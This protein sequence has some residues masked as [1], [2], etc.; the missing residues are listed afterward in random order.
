M[1]IYKDSKI[2][3]KTFIRDFD[4]TTGSDEYVWHRDKRDRI[5]EVLSEPKGWKFQ[6]DNE[7]PTEINKG[8]KIFIRS[9]DFHRLIKG[10]ND[11]KIKI[12]ER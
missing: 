6:F 12:S 7:L 3:R 1:K 2:N 9:F 5:V 4:H 8:D 10:E 11:L